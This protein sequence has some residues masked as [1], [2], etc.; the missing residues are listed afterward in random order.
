MAEQMGPSGGD[1]MRWF[2]ARLL[3]VALVDGVHPPDALEEESIRLLRASS[4]EDAT[5]RADEL[6]AAS[7]HEYENEAGQTVQWTFL[8]TIEVQDLCTED[9]GDGAEVFSTF[10]RGAPGGT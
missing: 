1:E 5:R 10:R 9:L 2:S 3:F 6:G 4:S 8:E 7:T